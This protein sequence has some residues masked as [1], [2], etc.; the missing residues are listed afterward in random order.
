MIEE[1]FKR[2]AGG[3]VVE[4]VSS[5]A[6]K[7]QRTLVPLMTMTSGATVTNGLEGR[8]LPLLDVIVMVPESGHGA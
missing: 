6:L 8:L 7:Y 2:I 3:Q 5:Q 4:Q 1:A